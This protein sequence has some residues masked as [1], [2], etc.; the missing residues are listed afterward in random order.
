MKTYN[1]INQK[2]FEIILKI[3]HNV[4]NDIEQ[5]VK[6][7][8]FTKLMKFDDVIMCVADEMYEKLNKAQDKYKLSK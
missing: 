6:D 4:L 7:S 2:R 3:A 5:K 1:S 8:N